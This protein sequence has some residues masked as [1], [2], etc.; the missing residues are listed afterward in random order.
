M[1]P[2]PEGDWVGTIGGIM[3]GLPMGVFQ[4]CICDVGIGDGI[5]VLYCESKSL[6]LMIATLGEHKIAQT[7]MVLIIR[8]KVFIAI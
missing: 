2:V 5:I 7:R 1:D 4:D 6:L 3:V 8:G